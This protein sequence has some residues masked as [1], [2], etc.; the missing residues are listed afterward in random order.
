[1]LVIVGESL[2]WVWGMLGTGAGRDVFKSFE[3][4]FD[5][6]L[7]GNIDVSLLIVPIQI[8]AAIQGTRPVDCV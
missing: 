8:Y 7:H 2:P 1:M 4:S 6:S 5:I 3:R